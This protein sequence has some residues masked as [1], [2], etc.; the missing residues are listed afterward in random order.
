MYSILES[1]MCNA[2]ILLSTYLE[3]VIWVG[4]VQPMPQSVPCLWFQVMAIL[5]RSRGLLLCPTIMIT[6]SLRNVFHEYN[7]PSLLMSSI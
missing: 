4:N 3:N 6:A 7:K 1:G 5:F 2:T